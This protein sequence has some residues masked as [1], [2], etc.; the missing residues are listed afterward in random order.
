MR[1]NTGDADTDVIRQLSSKHICLPH[2]AETEMTKQKLLD[3]QKIVEHENLETTVAPCWLR[4]V[5]IDPLRLP[6][7]C[8]QGD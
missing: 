6:A 4:V 3:T 8:R 5:I 2:D 1:S 7:G